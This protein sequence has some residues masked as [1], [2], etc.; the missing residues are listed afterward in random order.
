MHVAYTASWYTARILWY[1]FPW[2]LVAVVVA[3]GMLRRGEWRPWRARS[4]SGDEGRPAPWR[5]AWF[6]LVTAF[7][8]TAAFSLA[9]R[10]ADRYIF[11]VY[12][13]VAAAGAGAALQRSVVMRR[14]A[15]RMDRPWTP[16]VVYVGLVLLTLISSGR[17]PVFTF[18]RS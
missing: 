12:F 7:L 13:L 14:L 5:G 10:K 17:L 15:A 18:W 9:H 4:G 16:A 8:L 11:P 6:A 3:A 1:P 2:S